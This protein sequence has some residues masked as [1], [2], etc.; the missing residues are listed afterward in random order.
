[1]TLSEFFG[2]CKGFVVMWVSIKEVKYAI[3]SSK[4]KHKKA[5]TQM[6]VCFLKYYQFP[7]PPKPINETPTII[8]ITPIIFVQPR[9]SL[10]RK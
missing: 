2:I 4:A 7:C 6:D 1:M 10:K 8:N 9:G 5:D 3:M